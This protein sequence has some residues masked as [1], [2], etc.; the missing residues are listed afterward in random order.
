MTGFAKSVTL[1]LGYT[2]YHAWRIEVVR[3]LKIANCAHYIGRDSGIA[4]ELEALMYEEPMPPPVL[5][6]GNVN[7]AMVTEAAATLRSQY[8][9]NW[10]YG[11]TLVM[12]VGSSEITMELLL[13]MQLLPLVATSFAG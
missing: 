8:Q 12:S 9:V 4:D 2:N 11:S 6:S 10:Q 3:N 13:R 7:S 5:V 1:R